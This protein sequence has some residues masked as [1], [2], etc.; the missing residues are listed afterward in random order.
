MTII[1]V[2][3]EHRQV[4][5]A[6]FQIIKSP[7]MNAMVAFHPLTA[8]GKLKAVMQPIIPSGF[9]CSIMKCPGRSLGSTLPEMVRD[10][11]VAMSQ[12]SMYSYTSPSPSLLI[13]PISREISIPSASFFFL[14]ASP[15]CLTISPLVGGG[16]LAHLILS[17]S[18]AL[19]QSS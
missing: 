4:V 3:I 10:M 16:S 13:F 6:G 15:I 5:S 19:M 11:P 12:M 9:H 18:M 14:N 8:T 7:Q 2:A 1:Y 17:D